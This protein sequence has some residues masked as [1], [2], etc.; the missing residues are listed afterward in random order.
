[1]M[2]ENIIKL[3]LRSLDILSKIVI[4]HILSYLD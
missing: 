3:S 1:M 4:E 2:V